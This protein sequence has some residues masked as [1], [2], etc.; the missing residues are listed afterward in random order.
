[1]TGVQPLKHKKR[2][3]KCKT[4]VHSRPRSHDL[5]RRK[6]TTCSPFLLLVY[7]SPTALGRTIPSVRHEYAQ[8]IDSMRDFLRGFS[9]ESRSSFL[10]YLKYSPLSM[11]NGFCHCS[12]R[13][14]MRRACL[15]AYSSF[16]FSL[17]IPLSFQV[18]IPMILSF[19]QIVESFCRE[20]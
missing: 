19:P 14:W 15:S 10:R 17:D 4:K 12:N 1:M 5:I 6:V 3:E 8:E 11:P 16:S 13:C 20:L 2:D 7:L 9:Q 18:D